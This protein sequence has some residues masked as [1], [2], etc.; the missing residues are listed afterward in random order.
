MD[1][2]TRGDCLGQL[3]LG[4]VHPKMPV[5][6]PAQNRPGG[7]AAVIRLPPATPVD[8]SRVITGFDTADE[9]PGPPQVFGEQGNVCASAWQ[10]LTSDSTGKTMTARPA[11]VAVL[12]ATGSIGRSTLEVIAALPERFEVYGLSA[13]SQWELLL[14]LAHGCQPQCLVLSGAPDGWQPPNDRLPAGGGSGRWLRGAD[15]LVELASDR[16]VDTVVAAIV[17]RAG[18]ES[19]LAAAEAGKRIGLANK[20]SLVVA[21]SL[22][23]A[24]VARGGAELLPVD[25]EHSAIF[26]A[27]HT[28]PG[29]APAG[30]E[31]RR[32]ILT[33]SGGGLRHLPVEQLASVSV[34]QALR[35]PTWEM[36]PKI[37]IDSATM[38]NKAL[39]VIEAAWLFGLRADQIEVVVHPQSVVH[40]MVE[41]CDGSVLAQLSP[42]DMRLPI[43]YALT[44]P[45]RLPCPA[46]P[47]D[48][49]QPLG[50][51]WEPADR[52]RYPALELGFEVVRRGGSCGAVLNA[53]NEAAVALFLEH[54]IGF[55]D[56]TAVCRAVLDA[57][58][59]DPSPGLADLMRADG[60]ARREVQHWAGLKI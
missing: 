39:E 42:P 60:W 1:N 30:A 47:I 19:T 40:S 3:R 2:H 59:Y 33:A 21:G 16:Q 35:H 36:G 56:I 38:M 8:P 52:Q 34:D 46:P 41:F 49:T 11:R 15:A 50:L 31:L 54:K 27:L 25:S 45:D 9:L 57:H 51:T 13:H 26:Q 20:E 58:T 18:L 32:V 43:Q 17:G 53:A 4:Q 7:L 12:G 22:V 29:N 24:A 55:Q 10:L 23:T 48:W 28:A 37:T 44:F 14:E 6:H 5:L